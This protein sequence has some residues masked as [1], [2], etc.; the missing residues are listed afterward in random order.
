M[1]F[2]GSKVECTLSW[3]FPTV[4]IEVEEQLIRDAQLWLSMN[5]F[6]TIE[7]V[8]PNHWKFCASPGPLFAWVR[9]GEA[10]ALELCIHLET[11]IYRPAHT[12]VM[13]TYG[14]PTKWCRTSS[15]TCFLTQCMWNKKRLAH[16]F[17]WEAC[18]KGFHYS[19]PINWWDVSLLWYIM[20]E[21]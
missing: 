16:L 18:G 17:A 3:S 4:C 8:A 12:Y 21:W 1:N 7:I 10:G 14:I 2:F 19:R 5:C 20:Q 15:A 11:I 9:W 13:Q 6:A